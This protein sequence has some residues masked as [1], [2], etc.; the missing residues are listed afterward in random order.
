[1]DL[2]TK[3]SCRH[4]WEKKR[5]MNLAHTVSQK[6]LGIVFTRTPLPRSC[7]CLSLLCSGCPC[8]C[9]Y[10]FTLVSQSTKTL[11]AY[12]DEVL[13]T[14][15]RDNFMTSL[16]AATCRSLSYLGQ[17]LPYPLASSCHALPWLRFPCH[18][19][20]CSSCLFPVMLLVRSG[21][22]RF[23]PLPCLLLPRSFPILPWL[24]ISPILH[25]LL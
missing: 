6:F 10:L 23:L 16:C 4:K 11:L 19:F 3:Q 14:F 18:S 9:H 20:P 25:V 17:A 12:H 13:T 21:L 2:T 7:F 24:C 8:P 5:L 1:M 22:L 15:S